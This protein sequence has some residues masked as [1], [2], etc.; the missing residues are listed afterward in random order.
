[1]MTRQ[2]RVDG[3]NKK[4]HVSFDVVEGFDP[5]RQKGTKWDE[6]RRDSRK[7]RRTGPEC[8][9]AAIIFY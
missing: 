5:S 8:A 4:R 6:G 9:A 7:G 1:M 3:L 2:S